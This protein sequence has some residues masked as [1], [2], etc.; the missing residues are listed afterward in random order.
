MPSWR[1]KR[2]APWTLDISL[3][4]IHLVVETRG[5]AWTVGKSGAS[6]C[7]HRPGRSQAF[8]SMALKS[9]IGH[10]VW[11]WRW[12]FDNLLWDNTYGELANVPIGQVV[13]VDLEMRGC[14]ALA[15]QHRI[16][17]TRTHDLW[18][19]TLWVKLPWLS[20]GALLDQSQRLRVPELV[21]FRLTRGTCGALGRV[22]SRHKR[23]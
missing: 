1:C 23:H 4:A 10:L 15:E 17:W 9:V 12:A 11:T 22:D 21:P 6:Q 8:L 16:G 19:N 14:C 13:V 20:P 5:K 3:E 18:R 7:P 2:T